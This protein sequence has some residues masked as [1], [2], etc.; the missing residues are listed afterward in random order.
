[1]KHLILAV[2][3]VL[4]LSAGVAQQAKANWGEPDSTHHS[5]PYDNTGRGAGG[6]WLQGGG[7]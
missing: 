3:A 7:G 6:D 5:G 4:G 2:I 1:M